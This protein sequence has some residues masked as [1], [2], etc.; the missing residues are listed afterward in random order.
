MKGIRNCN[1]SSLEAIQHKGWQPLGVHGFGTS[2][3][4]ALG[5][6]LLDQRF[7]TGSIS[8]PVVSHRTQGVCLPMAATLARLVEDAGEIPGGPTK[9]P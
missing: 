3:C 1:G 5:P 8:S 7:D 9:G 4:F 2:G 6:C